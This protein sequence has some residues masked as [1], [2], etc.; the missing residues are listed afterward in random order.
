MIGLIFF[1]LSQTDTRDIYNKAMDLYNQGDYEAAIRELKRAI[2]ESP[3]SSYLHEAL[4][5]IYYDMED[6]EES[7][8][9]Y[10]RALELDP[11]NSDAAFGAAYIY[12][13][14]EMYDS[15]RYYYRLSI[16]IEPS[17]P[18]AHLNLGNVLWDM[19]DMRG[20]EAEYR[21][22]LRLE[23]T[24]QKA[25]YNLALLYENLR[26]YSLAE[27]HY[28]AAIDSDPED[29]DS[30]WNLTVLYEKQE[31][32][33]E[34]EEQLETLLEYYPDNLN[35]LY[36]LGTVKEKLG[37]KEGAKEIYMK[38]IS[39]DPSY[40][41]AY[42]RMAVLLGAA[43]ESDE[44]SGEELGVFQGSKE[45]PPFWGIGGTY[46]SRYYQRYDYKDTIIKTDIPAA[47][48][49]AWWGKY[50]GTNM[51]TYI[52][53]GANYPT[54]FRGAEGYGDLDNYELS[55]ELLR[56]F[57]GWTF[58]FGLRSRYY[59]KL[60][61]NLWEKS[62]YTRLVGGAY[63]FFPWVEL[64]I[65]S[66]W[67]PQRR[68]LR[69]AFWWE[70]SLSEDMKHGEFKSD[71]SFWQRWD[72]ENDHNGKATFELDGMSVSY[73]FSYNKWGFSA[74]IGVGYYWYRPLSKPVH[75]DPSPGPF[76]FFTAS[77]SK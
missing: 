30:R 6:Y 36:K 14:W 10:L 60:L 17:D 18:G 35:V 68:Y 26:R 47:Q 24:Y 50:I 74:G 22:A 16:R 64:D 2:A 54:K 52:D 43:G 29:Y 8:S 61:S 20:A 69:E 77:Y 34:A 48:A 70:T 57:E 59:P 7:L 49:Y 25:H 15:A 23:P 45:L 67:N 11:E 1:M 76:Y 37:N 56:Y 65:F 40:G 3:D 75:S 72:T 44:W 21:E 33:L 58:D 53:V 71:L 42:Y 73:K 39:D 38:I 62:L 13:Q 4:G 5:D 55:W 27:I 63:I 51:A 46:D 31:R 9:E 12:Q 66:V 41:E 32:Y 19:G 28:L